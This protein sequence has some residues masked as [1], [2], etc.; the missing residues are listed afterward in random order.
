LTNILND[1]FDGYR[2]VEKEMAAKGLLTDETTFD[3]MVDYAGKHVIIIEK[4]T[5]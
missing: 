5:L 2:M 4:E 3:E 1:I